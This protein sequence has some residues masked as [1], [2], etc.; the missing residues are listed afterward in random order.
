MTAFRE[1]VKKT[2]NF[3]HLIPL[4][5]QI[6]IFPKYGTIFK[7]CPLLPFTLM[8]K[9][10]NFQWPISEK[11]SKNLNFWHLIPLNPR[12]KIFPKY[13][14]TLKWCPLLPSTIMQKIRNF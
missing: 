13:G 5:P 6:K 7:W 4:N 10:R 11:M 3:R 12:I 14:T 9:I 8:Q 2:P 1:N